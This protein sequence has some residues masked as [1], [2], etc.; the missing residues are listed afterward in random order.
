M[1]IFHERLKMI[2]T[3]S[4]I[5]EPVYKSIPLHLTESSESLLNHRP[6]LA[7]LQVTLP[8]PDLC[9]CS[10]PFFKLA[11]EKDSF[12]CSIFLPLFVTLH[13][14]SLSSRPRLWGNRHPAPTRCPTHCNGCVF[15]LCVSN[16]L[17]CIPKFPSLYCLCGFLI[18]PNA[19]KEWIHKYLLN[20][21]K[22][23]KFEW[24]YKTIEVILKSSEVIGKNRINILNLIFKYKITHSF[25]KNL[26]LTR[27]G[28]PC[29]VWRL[30]TVEN[31]NRFLT[32]TVSKQQVRQ[33]L[34]RGV[35]P[36]QITPE[37]RHL[38]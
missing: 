27:R 34:Q 38:T 32:C 5:Q 4:R 12:V 31:R 11:S 16:V 10:F 13:F 19:N 17:L 29:I 23:I 6:K 1:C 7:L 35:C 36:R 30:G 20:R 14:G 18:E 33:K 25:N 9:F 3:G 15:P 28:V 8:L 26:L 21:K 22:K 2:H 37:E 24:K